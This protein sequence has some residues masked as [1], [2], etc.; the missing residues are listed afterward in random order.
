[1][2]ETWTSRK[3]EVASVY[4]QCLVLLAGGFGSCAAASY[5]SVIRT[6]KPMYAVFQ[7]RDMS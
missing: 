7:L 1:M 4:V 5:M 2:L 3:E 6:V